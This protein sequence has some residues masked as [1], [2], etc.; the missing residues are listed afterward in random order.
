MAGLN[1]IYD[2]LSGKSKGVWPSALRMGLRVLEPV[3]AAGAAIKNFRYDNNPALAQAVDAKVI[4]V[5]NLTT[6][7]TGKTPAVAMLLGWLADEGINVGI[8]SRGYK[9]QNADLNDEGKELKLLFPSIPHIQN[10]DRVLAA[11]QLIEQFAV[12]VILVDDGF[13]HRRLSRDLDIVLIDATNPFG[14]G[15]LL[16]R[17]LLREPKKSLKRAAIVIVTR[18]NLVPNSEI[19][20]LAQSIKQYNPDIQIVH[21]RQVPRH[22]VTTTGEKR[23]LEELQNQD[24]FAFC[25]IGNPQN[26]NHV[27]TN[28][29]CRVSRLLDFDDH[30]QYTKSDFERILDE[31][32]RL[33]VDKLVCTLK[34]LVKLVDLGCDS[35]LLYAMQ[36]QSEITTG[37]AQLRRTIFDSIKRTNGH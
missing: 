36:I 10:T 35:G 31:A 29:G 14:F 5:G 37:L 9:R 28:T 26:F 32:S 19:Q 20:T 7:G 2:L 27:L 11:Q 23:S 22:L 13:Q 15:H 16:P 3:Y 17:G 25:G 34:D 30:H 1:S 24:V 18:T 8:V 12:D 33:G 4:S 21:S 6:G